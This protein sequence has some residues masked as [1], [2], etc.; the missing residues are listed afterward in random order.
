[1]GRADKDPYRHNRC[2]DSQCLCKRPVIPVFVDYFVKS[3]HV[4]MI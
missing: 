4:H 3:L 1:M 2:A